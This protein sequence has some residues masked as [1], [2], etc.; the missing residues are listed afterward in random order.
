MVNACLLQQYVMARLIAVESVNYAVHIYSSPY[1]V[2]KKAVAGSWGGLSFKYRPSKIDPLS[3]T[4]QRHAYTS[5]YPPCLPSGRS[6]P[7]D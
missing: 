4:S 5:V 7:T 2:V 6:T 1:L 3:T